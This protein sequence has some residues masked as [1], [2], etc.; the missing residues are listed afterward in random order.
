MAAQLGKRLPVPGRYVLTGLAIVIFLPVF[1]HLDGTLY[2]TTDEFY[3]SGFRLS[4][5][6]LPL[7]VAASGLGVLLLAL[8]RDWPRDLT[9]LA[10]TAASIIATS[11]L[12]LEE[13]SRSK[14]LLCAQ[15]LLP[16]GGY[17]LG[18]LAFR[19]PGRELQI[20]STAILI[21]LTV[22]VPG[23]LADTWLSGDSPIL[24]PTFFGVGVYGHLQYVPT[25]FVALFLIG[26]GTTW[27]SPAA[28]TRHRRFIV[29]LAM[30]MGIYVASSMSMLA[31]GGFAVCLLAYA[32]YDVAAHRRPATALL[33]LAAVG[34]MILTLQTAIPISERFATKFALGTPDVPTVRAAAAPLASPATPAAAPAVRPGVAPAA[35]GSGMR[36]EADRSAGEQQLPVPAVDLSGLSEE[37]RLILDLWGE[38]AARVAGLPP[39]IAIRLG[40]WKH[41]TAG[42]LSSPGHFLFGRPVPPDRNRFPSAHNYYLDLAYNFGAVTVVP[43]V[44]LIGIT[45]AGV[46]RQRHVVVQN[47]PLF[48]LALGVAFLLLLDNQTRV[49]MRQPYPGIVAFFLWGVLMNLVQGARGAEQSSVTAGAAHHPTE[50]QP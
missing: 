19:Q 1:V 44:V 17:L 36:P 2:T 34:I 49:G 46:W 32:V 28:N 20:L 42:L 31:V 6:P 48:S 30:L 9:F 16:M 33:S 11:L 3:E 14:L 41:Y 26:L 40:Y 13:L 45:A 12:F 35:G 18:R 24:A 8:R 27:S 4:R 7:S 47:A 15:F 25:T 21:T 38:D 50:L 5:L 37:A 10:L 23:Q 29:V 39:N 22:V 43:I